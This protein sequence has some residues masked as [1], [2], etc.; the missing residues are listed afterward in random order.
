[1]TDKVMIA[2]QACLRNSSAQTNLMR[3]FINK[4][5]R[6]IMMEEVE[7]ETH[8][9]WPD[10]K[11]MVSV[12]QKDGLSFDL[13]DV[14]GI[15]YEHQES[16]LHP[17]T[18]AARLTTQWWGKRIYVGDEVTSTIDIAKSLPDDEHLHGSLVV[19]NM[20]TSGRGRRGGHWVSRKG[21]DI[22]L[23]FVVKYGEW[24]PTPSLL[25]LYAAVSVARVL[26]TAYHLPVSIKWPNDLYIHHRKL[27]G[28]LAEKDDARSCSMISLGLNVH[29]RTSDWPDECRETAT[30]LDM[31]KCVD[32]CRDLLIAQCGITWEFLWGVMQKEK[33]E[34]IRGY[35]R[36]YSSTLNK[37][38]TLHYQKDVLSGVVRDLNKEGLL[39]L[40]TATG[41]LFEL[42]PEHV[43]HLRLV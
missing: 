19:A 15:Q 7:D 10:I 5:S 37:R 35:W 9:S 12:L 20:Q 16:R 8:Y 18:I 32:F 33:G 41:S 23:T 21:N 3:C 25:S 31:E 17:D 24:Q 26:D 43:Q 11:K 29:S 22:L 30:S 14:Y 1:M 36:Q 34:T 2:E 6:C 42:L 38:V 4:P 13:E 27:G 28:I 40:E 39:V